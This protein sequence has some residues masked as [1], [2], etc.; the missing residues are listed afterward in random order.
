MEREMPYASSGWNG[1]VDTFI[2]TQTWSVLEALK[3]H[4]FDVMQMGSDHLQ[5][6]AW[7]GSVEMLRRMLRQLVMDRPEAKNWHIAFEY[8]L[9]RERGRR[10]DVILLADDTILV[11]E[12]KE[13]PRPSIA[14][15][16]QV[17]A[18]A[19]DIAHYHAESHGRP[20]HPILVMTRRTDDT[21]HYSDDVAI[22]GEHALLSVLDDLKTDSTNAIDA[23][24]WLEADYEPLPSLVAAARLLFQNEPLP[25]IRRAHSAGIPFT[26]ATLANIREEAIANGSKHLV[27]ITGVPGAGKTLVGLQ[28]VYESRDEDG[29][30]RTAVMLSGNVPLVQVL[31]HALKTGIFVQDVH[32]FLKQYGGS[33]VKTPKEHVLIYDEAQRAWDGD[34]VSEQRGHTN[35]EPEDFLLIGSRMDR[36]VL[37]VGL[38]GEGQE[39]HHGEEGGLGLWNDA[40]EATGGDW[41][42]HC[43]E[44]IAPLFDNAEAIETSATLDL[45]ESLRSHLARDVQRWV[46]HFLAGDFSA[47]NDITK[48]LREQGFDAYFSRDLEVCKEYVKGRYAEEVDKR[49]GLLASSQAKNLKRWGV[50]NEFLT[51]RKLKVGPWYNDPPDSPLSCCQLEKVATEFYSQGLELDFPIVCWG[52]DLNW[53]GSAWHLKRRGNRKLHDPLTL[54]RNGYRVLLSRGR[55]GFVVFVPPED[56]M[57]AVAAALRA[58]GITELQQQM[59]KVA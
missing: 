5:N 15:R 55:D 6:S 19:R 4:H 34:R 10:P 56:E 25:S 16:D 39:I 35:S 18:Y 2:R 48:T 3:Q 12:F 21:P 54:R 47:A 11:L 27:L 57:D 30:G 40:I 1:T 46:A 20:I 41:I 31:Q 45:S 53:N 9:P 23:E 59:V 51:M 33:Q 22:V 26:L 50:D 58:A 37:M 44:R 43:P 7:T 49:Y 36:W 29:S 28:F 52:D 17:S 38:I 8:V 24:E 32:G 42:V 14:F 13:S